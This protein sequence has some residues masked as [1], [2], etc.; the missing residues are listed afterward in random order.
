MPRQL[1]YDLSSD[2]HYITGYLEDYTHICKLSGR[3]RA[4]Q[5]GFNEAITCAKEIHS[6]AEKLNLKVTLCLSGGVD[7]E[8]MARAFWAAKIPFVVTILKFTNDLNYF[9]IKNAIKFCE[10]SNIEYKMYEI[11]ILKFFENKKY[12]A[13]GKKYRCQSPQL[14]THLHLLD[15]LP[16]NALPVIAGQPLEVH[17]Q[18]ES[19]WFM[20]TGDLHAVYNRYFKIS[21]KYGVPSFF[22]YSPEFIQSMLLTPTIKTFSRENFNRIL[23]KKPIVKYSYFTKVNT[24]IDAGFHVTAREAKYTGF[25]EVRNHYDKVDNMIKGMAF[26]QRYRRPLE[27]LSPFPKKEKQFIPNELFKIIKSYKVTSALNEVSI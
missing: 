18:D 16:K 9:D 1:S 4:V 19:F 26:D 22:M 20:L 12:L 5:S 6:I 2:S 23:H 25:E 10:E 14:A 17:F 7:S 24:M 15:K 21:K 11:D 3:R 13:Y 8:A 27:A